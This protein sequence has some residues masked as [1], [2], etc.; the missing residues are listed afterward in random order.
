MLK[1]EGSRHDL[2]PGSRGQLIGTH[3]NGASDS[4]KPSLEITCIGLV[5]GPSN[6]TQTDSTTYYSSENL[7]IISQLICF[8]KQFNAVFFY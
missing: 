1:T 8:D 2:H 7:K 3:L 4:K 6:Q 5:A